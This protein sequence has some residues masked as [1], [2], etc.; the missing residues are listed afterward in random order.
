M[1]AIKCKRIRVEEQFRAP[2]RWAPGDAGFDLTV[3]RYLEVFPGVNA[4]LS[5]N[6][7]VQIPQGYFGMIIPRSST[8]AHKG[9]HVST[10][11]VDSG[12][13]GEIMILVRNLTDR[14]T[15]IQVGDRV[16]QLLILPLIAGGFK[17][18]EAL[19]EGARGD[20]GFGSTG[21]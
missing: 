9:L 7:A 8:L 13:R 3:S 6:I 5:T 20:A 19:D 1:K 11:I 12:Y 10:G 15:H 18:S 4:H 21:R 2:F 14:A 16:A 17:E